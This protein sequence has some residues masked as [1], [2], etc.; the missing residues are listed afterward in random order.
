LATAIENRYKSHTKQ[1]LPLKKPREFK[2]FKL[3]QGRLTLYLF[4]PNDIETKYQYKLTTKE[5]YESV[6]TDLESFKAKYLGKFV[7]C[8]AGGCYFVDFTV[9]VT[10]RGAK[11]I[12]KKGNTDESSSGTDPLIS[13]APSR[14]PSEERESDI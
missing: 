7:M 13:Q 3:H 8:P 10:P 11:L 6:V 14:A 1:A 9:M 4:N 12:F 2:Y 5:Q